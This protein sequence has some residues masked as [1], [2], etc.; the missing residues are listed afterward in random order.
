MKWLAMPALIDLVLAGRWWAKVL[1]AHEDVHG[2]AR[3][4]QLMR[5]EK[6]KK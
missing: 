1:K 2:A 5:G 6:P 3:L 4:M